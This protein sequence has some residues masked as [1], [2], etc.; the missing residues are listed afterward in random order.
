MSE[1]NSLKNII[2]VRFVNNTGPYRKIIPALQSSN[3]DDILVYAD[4]DVIYGYDWLDKLISC[5]EKY[6]GEYVV[7]S[8]AR[9]VTQNLLGI[10]K[11]YNSYPI[12]K[13]E[14]HLTKDFII[15]GVGGA[16]LMRKHIKSE[17]LL[18]NQYLVIAPK[19]DDLWI[20]KLIELS[21]CSVMP[22]P[23]A[24]EN[25]LEIQHSNFSL[26]STN[27]L[28]QKDYGLLKIL[29]KVRDKVFSYFGL[30]KTN[31]DICYEKINAYFGKIKKP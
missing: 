13:G 28:F 21:G 25:V 3:D 30:L 23:Q 16:V 7:A 9:V 29:F 17:L 6:N 31:N 11:S 19:T 14:A 12:A 5:F 27:T 24:L 18:D 22:C 20:S 26:S 15:T 1:L 2:H 4:D 10:R 8:R